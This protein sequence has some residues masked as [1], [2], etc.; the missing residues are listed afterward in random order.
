LAIARW[1]GKGEEKQRRDKGETIEAT[2]WTAPSHWVGVWWPKVN[3]VQPWLHPQEQESGVKARSDL[4]GERGMRGEKE[5][6][7]RSAFRWTGNS[8][9]GVGRP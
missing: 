4:G 5:A 7:I 9:A 1:V 2:A 3:R 6:G 8:F